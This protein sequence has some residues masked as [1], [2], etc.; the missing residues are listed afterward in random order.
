M[1]GLLN[2]IIH[3]HM[4]IKETKIKAGAIANEF[5]KLSS[6]TNS[7]ITN[8]K[9]LKICYIA[10]GLSLSILKRTA[11][12]EKI[13][14]WKYGPVI[15]SLYH[16]FKHFRAKPITNYRSSE[17]T[18]GYNFQENILNDDELKAIIKLTWNLYGDMTAEMLVDLTHEKGTPWHFTWYSMDET[19]IKL[20]LIKT[21]YDQFIENLNLTTI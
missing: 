18:D 9:L 8:L 15:P 2:L 4:F 16:E 3:L 5:L 10:Q 20:E 13:E 1:L 21:Y 19:T 7:S 11:F 12:S 14:A 17:I 6:E